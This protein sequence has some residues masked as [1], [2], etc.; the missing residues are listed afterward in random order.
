MGTNL[1]NDAALPIVM[2]L[3]LSQPILSGNDVRDFS[4]SERMG[5]QSLW[6][7][8]RTGHWSTRRRHDDVMKLIGARIKKTRL[9]QRHLSNCH[10]VDVK[11][12]STCLPPLRYYD[13]ILQTHSTRARRVLGPRRHS[14][15]LVA[16]DRRRSRHTIDFY[17]DAHDELNCANNP[18]VLPTSM[19]I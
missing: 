13:E 7:N 18:F 3:C 5:W 17:V 2:R 11:T 4:L 6:D 8:K 15:A 16:R 19:C 12:C 10:D 1:I 14:R 9:A